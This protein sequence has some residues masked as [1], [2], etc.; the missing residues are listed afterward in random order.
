MN[1]SRY[2]EILWAIIWAS[3]AAYFVSMIVREIARM[4]SV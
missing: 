4:W 3:V 1:W 2:P